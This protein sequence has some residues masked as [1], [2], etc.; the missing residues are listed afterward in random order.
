MAA[1]EVIR[2]AR[3]HRIFTGEGEVALSLI[4]TIPHRFGATA[5]QVD[6]EREHAHREL[7]GKARA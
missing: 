7:S 2:A 3:A 4:Q 1:A 5:E 6:R